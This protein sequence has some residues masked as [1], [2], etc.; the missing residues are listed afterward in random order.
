MIQQQVQ[1]IKKRKSSELPEI[2]L[3]LLMNSLELRKAKSDAE[4]S[5]IG[6][7]WCVEQSRD[8]IAHGVPG[9]HYYTMSLSE[10]I[11]KVVKKV[12]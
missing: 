11:S 12:F 5:E 9:I 10:G 1:D 4:A 2:F 3:L 8:L 6:V 7:R